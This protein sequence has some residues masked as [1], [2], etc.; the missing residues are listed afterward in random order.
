M[1]RILDE[2]N[3]KEDG[4]P[5][6]GYTLHIRDHKETVWIVKADCP[7]WP[8]G[9][10]G[11]LTLREYGPAVKKFNQDSPWTCERGR[12]WMPGTEGEDDGA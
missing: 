3:P 8:E 12:V 10:T 6:G 4:R 1:G 2:W 9:T 11:R 7:D 5:G